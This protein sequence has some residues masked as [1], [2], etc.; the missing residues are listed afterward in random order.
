MPV[1]GAKVSGHWE[2][3]TNGGDKGLTDAEGK[4]TLR[5]DSLNSPTGGEIFTF[6]VD[7]VTETSWV[8]DSSANNETSDSI[9][10]VIP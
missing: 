2:G 5:S 1:R 6:V 3:A 8:Y 7:D 10:Y 4:I 9:I